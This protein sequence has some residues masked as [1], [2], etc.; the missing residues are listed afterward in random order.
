MDNKNELEQDDSAEQDEAK[1]LEPLDSKPVD[2]DTD[3][4]QSALS[5]DFD[6]DAALASLS[7]LGDAIAEHEHPVAIQDI[8][9]ADDED[10]NDA[11]TVPMQRR[12]PVTTQ[13]YFPRPPMT[14]LQR[15]QM[16]SVIPAIVLIAVGAW[17]TFALTT[18]ETPLAAGTV[19][20]VLVV[21]LGVVMLGHWFSSRRWAQGAFFG[22]VTL[23]TG[24]S[25]LLYL[26]QTDNFDAYPLLLVA[27]GISFL[28]TALLSQVR[29]ALM[30]FTGVALIIAGLVGLAV[31]TGTIAIDAETDTLAPI[32]LPILIGV[33]VVL[34]VLPVIFKRRA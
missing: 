22:G 31:T 15:G 19:A 3:A 23:I 20:L 33:L 32:L 16:G 27:P 4:I 34:V 21:A 14:R 11:V 9:Q 12:E 28:L 30:G 29:S 6:V 5:N 8:A 1:P 2:D 24:A 17:W 13:S 7:S 10:D 25:V 26:T 18:S